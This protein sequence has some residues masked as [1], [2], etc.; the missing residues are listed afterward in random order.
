MRET[1]LARYGASGAREGARGGR[2]PPARCPRGRECGHRVDRGGER[3]RLLQPHLPDAASWPRGPRPSRCGPVRSAAAALRSIQ[4]ATSTSATTT[5]GSSGSGPTGSSSSSP[6]TGRRAPENNPCGDGG[7][8]TSAQ[9]RSAIGVDVAA[10]GDV[11][12]VDYQAR[13]VRKVRASDGVITTIAGNGQTTPATTC[14]YDPMLPMVTWPSCTLVED[15][16]T[17][18]LNQPQGI[19]VAAN[20]IVYFA[21]TDSGVVR[22]LIPHRRRVPHAHGRAGL[23][24]QLPSGRRARP[25]GDNSCTWWTARSACC[26]STSPTTRVTPVAGTANTACAGGANPCGDG[27]PAA[28]ATLEASRRHRG[29]HRQVRSTSARTRRAASASSRRAAVI[30]TV[31]GTGVACVP[32]SPCGD[33]RLAARRAVP[34]AAR[35]RLRA[36]A[37]RLWVE[38]ATGTRASASSRRRP[39]RPPRPRRR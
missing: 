22:R 30:T 12:I 6:A 16:S 37:G 17:T 39:A 24:V 29:R 5:S 11:F 23:H 8:A 38:R 14:G 4:R 25:D 7:P 10:N 32:P 2:A 36:A 20:G 21:E 3:G 35:A 26:A 27:G 1:R 9:L 28:F 13:K 15:A 31:A 19:A 34:S 33:G 18:G